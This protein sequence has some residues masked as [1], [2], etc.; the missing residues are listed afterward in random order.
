MG[1]LDLQRGLVTQKNVILCHSPKKLELSWLWVA[2]SLSSAQHV[3][4]LMCHRDHSHG[5]AVRSHQGGGVCVQSTPGTQVAAEVTQ[6]WEPWGLP[7]AS[8][9]TLTHPSGTETRKETFLGDTPRN[10]DPG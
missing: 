3:P 1:V 7:P 2:A 4:V 10:V 9:G 5:L 8:L 6:R